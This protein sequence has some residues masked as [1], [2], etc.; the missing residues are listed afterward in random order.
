M[1]TFFSKFIFVLFI[2][3]ICATGARAIHINSI[4]HQA[5]SELTLSKNDLNHQLNLLSEELENQQQM[6]AQAERSIDILMN[7]VSALQS[8]RDYYKQLYLDQTDKIVYLTFDD[9]PSTTITPAILDILLT[10]DI[11]ATFF[12][13]GRHSERSPDLIKRILA[14]GH[15]IGNHSYSH[16]YDLIYASSD[17]FEADFI[18]AQDILWEITG[19]YPTLFRFPGGSI[20]AAP[21]TPLSALETILWNNNV[22]YFDWDIDSGDAHAE[23]ASAEQIAN[24]V[25][26]QLGKKRQ[27]I[28]LLHDSDTKRATLEALPTIIEALAALGYRFETLDR[29]GYTSQFYKR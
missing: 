19:A 1:K 21:R 4:Q 28:I 22:Q 9:G 14:E 13:T 8:E 25:M 18:K 27:A 7:K 17:H 20:A 2:L 29:Y 26:F 3:A 12:V 10:Y 11:R 6:M 23:P 16:N 24:N 5:V 15:V